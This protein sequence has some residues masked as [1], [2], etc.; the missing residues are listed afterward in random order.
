MN[1]KWLA[2]KGLSQ[3]LEKKYLYYFILEKTTGKMENQMVGIT[4]ESNFFAKTERD[5][6]R[7]RK[8]LR[9]LSSFTSPFFF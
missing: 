1:Y 4:K 3:C 8:K 9:N 6:T 7:V 5:A 2:S